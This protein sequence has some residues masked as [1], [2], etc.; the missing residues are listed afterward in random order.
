M[1]RRGIWTETVKA[2]SPPDVN[3]LRDFVS[4]HMT[5]IDVEAGKRVPTSLTVAPA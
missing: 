1:E 3:V 2:P 5:D 4:S